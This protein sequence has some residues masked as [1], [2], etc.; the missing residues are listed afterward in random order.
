[1]SGHCSELMNSLCLRSTL[2]NTMNILCG[3]NLFL[4]KNG[5]RPTTV[6]LLDL[7]AIV[8]NKRSQWSSAANKGYS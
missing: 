6:V 7:N 3:A 5:T 1:M 2:A 4:A 8:L